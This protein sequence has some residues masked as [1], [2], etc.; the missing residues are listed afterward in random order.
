MQVILS[1]VITYDY[2][3][4]FKAAKESMTVTCDPRGGF[5]GAHLIHTIIYNH[6]HTYAHILYLCHVICIYVCIYIYISKK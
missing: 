1:F 3:S 4:E 5:C 6:I 2:Y